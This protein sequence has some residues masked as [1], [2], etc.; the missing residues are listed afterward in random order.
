MMKT[1]LT[2][3]VQTITSIVLIIMALSVIFI[4]I[5][6]SA[7]PTNAKKILIPPL[8]MSTG[9]LM[10]LFPPTHIPWAWAGISFLCGALLFSI[11]LIITSK[12]ETRER[13]VYLKRSPAFIFILFGLLII[14]LALHGYLEEY[15]TIPQTGAIFFILAFGMLVPWRIAMYNQYQKVLKEHKNEPLPT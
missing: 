9:F 6:A 10:F 13:Q 8:G 1:F 11:P 3:H 14:R 7:K 4:R 12:F 5:K 2:L 15:L